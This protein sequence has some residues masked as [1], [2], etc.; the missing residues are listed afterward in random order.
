[1]DNEQRNLAISWIVAKT[2]IQFMTAEM[3]V[4]SKKLKSLGE[5][6]VKKLFKK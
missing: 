3:Y 4:I 6:Y 2:F 5:E 1:M